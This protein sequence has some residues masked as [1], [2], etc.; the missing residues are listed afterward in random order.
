MG[1]AVVRGALTLARVR[2]AR[3]ARVVVVLGG[4][5][6][7]PRKEGLLLVLDCVDCAGAWCRTTCGKKA[8]GPLCGPFLA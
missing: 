6:C 3:G 8:A 5:P 1:V 7:G 2:V 4:R